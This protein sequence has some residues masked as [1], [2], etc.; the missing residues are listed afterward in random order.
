MRGGVKS[1]RRGQRVCVEVKSLRGGV[2]S[3]RR[4]PEFAWRSR[5]CVEVQT[6]REG[7]DFAW[8]CPEFAWRS[9]VC[10]EV[11]RVCVEVNKFA[12]RS[13]LCV[14]VQTL[15]RGQDFASRSRVCVEV[16]SMREGVQSLRGGQD[17][18]WRS[19]LCVEVESLRKLF[20]NMCCAS[21]SGLRPQGTTAA[22][23]R[24]HRR[25]APILRRRADLDAAVLLSSRGEQ[26]CRPPAPSRARRAL[27][28]LGQ[29][30]NNHHC[31]VGGAKLRGRGKSPS[32]RT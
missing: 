14:E 19:R 30:E 15:R 20:K 9:R 4:G 28:L 17:S 10:V 2:Q 12:W 27:H 26:R 7:S 22:S 5:V 6:L 3:L 25:R 23:C 31:G 24:P 29:R 13:R 8:R 18:A 21:A 1:L 32:R 16:Q 11:S